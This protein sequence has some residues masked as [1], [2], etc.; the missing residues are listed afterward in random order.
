MDAASTSTVHTNMSGVRSLNNVGLVA[1]ESENDLELFLRDGLNPGSLYIQQGLIGRGLELPKITYDRI[2][3]Y[4]KTAGNLGRR[5][6]QHK[7]VDLPH[8]FKLTSLQPFPMTR[9]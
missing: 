1:G 3:Q 4:L 8:H 6:S 5:F 2:G 9:N 7:A